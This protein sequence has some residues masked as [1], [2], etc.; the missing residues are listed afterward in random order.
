MDS[1]NIPEC[2]RCGRHSIVQESDSR[3]TCL[4]CNFSKD[5]SHDRH[6]RTEDSD[7][8]NLLTA[9]VFTGLLVAITV[10]AAFGTPVN[11]DNNSLEPW[12]TP[13]ST[14]ALTFIAPGR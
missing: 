8:G 10:E 9:I 14:N 7:S 4:N 5:L 3:W 2:P 6:H 11:S 1:K 13:T 12:T